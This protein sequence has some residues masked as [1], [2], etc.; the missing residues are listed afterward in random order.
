MIVCHCKGISERS[1]RRAV[2]DGAATPG[3]L[4][5]ACSAGADCG[6]CHPLLQEIIDQE[7]TAARAEAAA[8]QHRSA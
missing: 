4:G 5:N 7:H 8:P 6:G 1:V 2:R 3:E